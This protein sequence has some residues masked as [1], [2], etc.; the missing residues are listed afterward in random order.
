MLGID[1][2]RINRF[3]SLKPKVISRILTNRE[4]DDYAKAKNKALFLATR[5]AIKEAIFK[6][7]NSFVI[8]NEIEI[9][10][11]NGKYLFPGFEISTSNEENE[12]IAIALKRK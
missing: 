12:V 11:S 2:T 5:W 4:Q 10:K 6:A 7:D 3:E 9:T 1:L 8:F